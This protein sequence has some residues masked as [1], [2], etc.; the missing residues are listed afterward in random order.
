MTIGRTSVPKSSIDSVPFFGL[1]R[2]YGRYRQEFLAITDRVLSTG[3]V[4]QGEDVAG[5]ECELAMRCRRRYCVAVGSCTDAIAFGLQACGIGAGD[6]VLVTALSFVASASP[7][8]RVGAT[9]RFVDIDSDYCQMDISLLD[10]MVTSRTK[11]LLAVHLY[12]QTLP[13]DDIEAFGARHGIVIMED[14]AQAL[15][16]CDGGRP[17]GSLGRV[18]C[19][20]FDPTK[21]IGSFSSAGAL[22]TDDPTIAEAVRRLRYHGREPESR[23]YVEPGYNS[24]LPSE[25]AGM[26]RFKLGQLSVWQ[27]ERQAVADHYLAELCE[28]RATSLPKVRPGSTHNWHKFVIRVPD[29]QDLATSLSAAR[30]QTMVHYARALPDE[31]L[32]QPS[33]RLCTSPVPCARRAVG[34]VLSLPI[35][36]D[37]T[38]PEVAY[39]CRTIREHYAHR[40]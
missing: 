8:L 22:L 17:A 19:V 34:E 33:E 4:L 39:V 15:G 35:Y 5:L 11:A 26:L 25:M 36:P 27:S 21:V 28:I 3:Q 24:Q 16:A 14:A 29:R 2:Q 30:I 6:E 1:D 40:R 23:Q 31:P 13:M 9:P 20:S 12:G 32:F 38:Q 7:I 18:S 10:R 37:L